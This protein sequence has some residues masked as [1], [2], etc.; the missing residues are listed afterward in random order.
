MSIQHTLLSSDHLSAEAQRAL[1]P[2]PAKMMAARGLA[3]LANPADLLTVLYQLAHDDS[4]GIATAAA[5]SAAELPD[6]LLEAALVM[7][8]VDPRVLDYYATVA[9][10]D[11]PR[12]VELVVLN[13]AAA[14]ETIAE[15][16]AHAEGKLVDAIAQNEQ[17]L[18]RHPA[19][20]AAMYRNRHARMS[21][22]DRAVELAIRNDVKVADIP[23]WEELVA[24][25]MQSGKQGTEKP[26]DA[27]ADELFERAARGAEARGGE[28][29]EADGSEE[30]PAEEVPISQM[31][32]PMK[33]RLAMMG[34]AFAR[35][36]LIRDPIRL[37]AMAT[38]KSPGVKDAEALKY[39]SNNSLHEDV[40]AYIARNREWTKLYTIKLSLVNNAKCPLALSMRLMPHLREKDLRM[41]AKSK[42]IPSAL[43]ANAKKLVMNRSGSK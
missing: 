27:A 42:N 30:E 39:A 19:I 14:D 6:H 11:R 40:I 7:A 26:A 25:V 5:K 13:A 43:S 17:R 34:N 38:I 33:I 41:L 15:L 36:Q 12:A 2:G 1:A 31:T 8:T 29:V 35:A 20:I 23:A 4:A 18:L 32:V 3:P 37:V 28:I 10:K 24:A 22:I 16:A 21:T 9:V